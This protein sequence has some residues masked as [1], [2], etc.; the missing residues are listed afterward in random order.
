MP[1]RKRPYIE[2]R[3]YN[4]SSRFPVL[5]LSGEE[6]R[7]SD[8]ASPRLH[9][10]NCL[11][12]GL[13]ES[14]SGTMIFEDTK[15]PFGAGDLTVISCDVPHTTYSSPGTAS[16]WS[17]LFVDL[18]GL[19]TPLFSGSD[20]RIF[21]LLNTL[22]HRICLILDEQE[23]PGIH[24]LTAEIMREL[25]QREEYY[26]VSV[27]GLFLALLADLVRAVLQIAGPDEKKDDQPPENALVIAPALEYIRS[28]YM[29]DFSMEYLAELCSLSP[30][31][32]RRL[33]SAVM[34]TSPLKFLNV[35]RIRQAAALL[36]TTEA[37]VL[38][39]SEEVGYRSVSSFNRQFRDTM[40]QTPHEWRRRMSILKDQSVMK[41][42]GFLVPETLTPDEPESGFRGTHPPC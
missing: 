37:S 20:L 29:D 23:Y 12:I 5:L 26:E 39:I 21:N 19:L 38:S 1:R 31:H 2:F 6:W 7:I 32:F 33:F 25:E 41:Y 36:R 42:R 3:D 30:A 40:G 18:T 4:L 8:V 28:H 27:R 34:E 16:K 10:H 35:T 13:C 22:E 15:R 11:E 17:Y 9:I 14:D 24:A